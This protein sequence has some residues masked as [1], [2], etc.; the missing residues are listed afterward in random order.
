MPLNRRQFLTTASAALAATTLDPRT[1]LA[2]AAGQA[3]PETAFKLLRRGV[4]IFTGQGG[5][6][7]WF[8]DREGALVIDSQF[9]ATAKIC[10]EGLQQRMQASGTGVSPVKQAQGGTGVSPVK[11]AQGGTGVSPASGRLIDFLVNTHHHGDHVAGNGVFQPAV[12]KILA[13]VNVPKLQR[14]ASE[15]RGPG[16]PGPSTVPVV[17]NATFDKAWHEEIGREEMEARYYG[18]A[19]TSG[20]A[21]VILEKANVVHMGDLVFNRMHPFIDRPAGASI[22]SWITLLDRVPAD[23]QRDTTYIFGHG[24]PKFGVT[25]TSADLKYM[26]DYLAALLDFV[27]AE[28][29]RGQP[30][31]AIVRITDPLKGFADHGPLVERTLGP[32]YDELAGS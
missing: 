15:R 18:P 10:L 2:Q 5:T 12:R 31:D 24:N 17:A 29:K 32:A 7:G 19:H 13:H 11:Q 20:D 27:Q 21:V 22:A 6:I 8:V 4:G 28:M 1:L 30:R 16:A 25:G 3:P 14:E 23:M 26:R 9:P